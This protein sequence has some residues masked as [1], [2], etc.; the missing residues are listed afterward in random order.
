MNLIISPRWRPS[1]TYRGYLSSH[2]DVETAFDEISTCSLVLSVNDQL[3]TRMVDAR[4]EEQ[5]GPRVSAYRLAEWF[6]WNWWRIRWEPPRSGD[7]GLSWRQAHET[8]SIGGGW[9]WPQLAFESDGKTVTVRSAGSEATPTEPVSYLGHDDEWYITAQEF[10]SGVDSFVQDVLS[11]LANNKLVPNPIWRIWRELEQERDNPET[12][13]Y[14]RFEA[15]LGHNP[16]E[17]DPRQI[18]RLTRDGEV[19]GKQAANE[20]AAEAPMMMASDTVTATSLLSVA[21]KSGFEVSDRNGSSPMTDNTMTLMET[22]TPGTPLVPWQVGANAAKALRR[23]EHLGDGPVSDRIL[24][25][26]C[27]IPTGS[28]RRSSPVKPPMAYT[29]SSKRGKYIVFRA[30]VPTGRRFDAARLLGD[31]LLVRNGES[32][33]PATSTHTFRQKMQRAFAAEFLCPF[34]ALLDIVK[35]DYSDESIDEAATKFRVS[36]ML[37]TRRLENNDV[38]DSRSTRR[39]P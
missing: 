9:L 28:L 22:D 20:V 23:S 34:D 15:L 19:W 2:I 16:D 39:I 38:F 26:M 27:G 37:V 24:C 25:D 7:S 35:G 6:L 32:L 36:P 33:Q 12:T 13:M 3:M 11:H 29:L 1:H 14:R 4:Q 8:A 18:D 21:R 17:A 31:K 30:R 10:E 5:N